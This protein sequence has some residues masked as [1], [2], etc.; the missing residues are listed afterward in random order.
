MTPRKTEIQELSCLVAQGEL[1][2]E[3]DWVNGL[4]FMGA[5]PQLSG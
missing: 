5:D 2:H 4:V 3:K 1:S